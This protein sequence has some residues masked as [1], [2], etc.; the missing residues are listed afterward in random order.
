MIFT[1]FVFELKHVFKAKWT[2]LISVPAL[3]FS[4]YA[5]ISLRAVWTSNILLGIFIARYATL[6]A[7][8]HDPFVEGLLP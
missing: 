6:V 2:L 5:L 1:V 4:C 3:A 8:R 7:K